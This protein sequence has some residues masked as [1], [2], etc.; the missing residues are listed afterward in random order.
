MIGVG[1]SAG[2]TGAKR[3]RSIQDPLPALDLDWATD[4]SL[5]AA[6]GPTPS[7][8]RASTG[9][10]FTSSGVLSSAAINAPRFN[11]VYN[12]SSWVS[13]GLLVEEQRTNLNLYSEQFNNAAYSINQGTISTNQA[14]SPDGNTTAESLAASAGTVN[15]YAYQAVTTVTSS[16]YTFSIYV[17]KN[18]HDFVQIVLNG[19]AN[20][21]ANFNI[22]SGVVGTLGAGGSATSSIVNVG[23]GWYRCIITY[24]AAGTTSAG[25]I[26]LIGSATA[27]RGA[28]FTAA[29]TE[30][31]YLWGQQLELGSFA[32][33]YI[34][35]TTAAVTRSADVCQITGT[36]FS[37]FWNAS[38]GSLVYEADS[39]S[40]VIGNHFVFLVSDVTFNNQYQSSRSQ[41]NAYTDVGFWVKNGNVWQALIYTSAGA[42]LQGATSK[43]A[44]AYKVDDFAFSDDGSA[45]LTDASGTLPTVNRME[46]G[47]S[48]L[49]S[50]AL[51][52]HIARLRYFNTRLT[53]SKLQELST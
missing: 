26:S 47:G 52:G 41:N 25:Y 10:Y 49:I 51:N 22:S 8:S 28:T 33:S 39:S 23:N 43:D 11:H 19:V 12:G 24:T 18:T 15:P 30:S 29:G 16:V 27:G 46:I 45:V 5:P 7:F 40:N 36:D 42:W 17:K 14:A 3:A 1:I 4:R 20:G 53:N 13:K 21:F 38:E 9:T 50:A 6:Y 32:T 44:M 2:L 35:T 48:S 34:P 37:S 31:V